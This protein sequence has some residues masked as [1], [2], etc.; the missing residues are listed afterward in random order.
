[1][2]NRLL[3]VS[4][5]FELHCDEVPTIG[6]SQQL[7]IP[8]LCSA[9]LPLPGQRCSGIL[10]SEPGD[11]LR[12][13][14]PDHGAG[15]QPTNQ[16]QQTILYH[17]GCST[18][19]QPVAPTF[20]FSLTSLTTFNTF[21]FCLTFVS[22][23]SFWFGFLNWFT[24]FFLMFLFCLFGLNFTGLVLFTCY[25]VFSHVFDSFSFA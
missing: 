7:P 1:M 6:T 9:Q 21:T 18:N 12:F 15:R 3:I 4:L 5:P 13:R 24:C 2:C 23:N 17:T 20:H 11:P 19:Q 22:V 14:R 16:A 10:K 8:H 25:F